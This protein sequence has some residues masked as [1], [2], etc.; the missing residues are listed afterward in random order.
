MRYRTWLCLVLAGLLFCGCS[1][2]NSQQKMFDPQGG[3][4]Y[5][6]MLPV[7]QN[8]KENFVF[9]AFSGGGSRAAAL[10]YDTLYELS[11]CTFRGS[12]KTL[13]DEVDVISSVSGGSFTAAY[14]GLYG[15]KIFDEYEKNF[16][17]KN[18][19]RRLKFQLL[20]PYN[21][22]RLISPYFNRIDLAAEYYDRILFQ[23]RTYDDILNRPN[24]FIIL[25]ATDI[26]IGAPF[27]FTQEYFDLLGSS[28]SDYPVSRAV[29]A[30]SAFPFLLSPLTLKN[31]PA[32]VKYQEPLWVANT[33]NDDSGADK[34]KHREAANIHS[35]FDPKRRYIHLIDGGVFDNLGIDRLLLRV[36]STCNLNSGYLDTEQ[37]DKSLN[38][39]YRINMDEIKRIIFITVNAKCSGDSK[40]DEHISPNVIAVMKSTISIPMNLNIAYRIDELRNLSMKKDIKI[41][42][43]DISF[44]AIKDQKLRNK[45]NGID[46]SFDITRKEK[47]YLKAA[48]KEALIN[49]PDLKKLKE[50]LG[51]AYQP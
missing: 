32:S 7:D 15:K 17:D 34:I 3:Y 30:S 26:S 39:L 35:Y 43:I 9:L 22:V 50:E 41:Y 4:R 14:Y 25:N 21:S 45:C 51:M 38:L 5:G 27:E 12:S 13:L 11:R 40:Y 31:Y 46:T 16:L 48:V 44:D 49:S 42:H 8:S 10:S 29:A 24:P 28:I 1:F 20:N 36:N 18:I 33:L 47:E 2:L 6:N 23:K 19:T 37:S